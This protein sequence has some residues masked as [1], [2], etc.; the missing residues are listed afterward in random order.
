[1]GVVPELGKD[2]GPLFI[3]WGIQWRLQRPTMPIGHCPE[4]PPP[5]FLRFSLRQDDGAPPPRPR[6]A[7]EKG[8]GLLLV[9]EL[10]CAH[11]VP[12]PFQ[13]PP[14]HLPPQRVEVPGRKAAML[15]GLDHPF[16]AAEGRVRDGRPV[17]LEEARQREGQPAERLLLRVG[18]VRDRPLV[19]S[20]QITPRPPFP[21]SPRLA[22]LGTLGQLGGS[23]ARSL[24]G[25]AGG[26]PRPRSPTQSP[27]LLPGHRPC[28]RPGLGRPV[29]RPG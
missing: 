2:S 6:P 17:P 25:S 27:G 14:P 9:L 28:F 5:P 1:M 15:R 29:R 19:G 21:R 4:P 12:A 23:R 18:P 24:V 3:G 10:G 20:A 26:T 13:V 8:G 11:S 16:H 22:P 7:L